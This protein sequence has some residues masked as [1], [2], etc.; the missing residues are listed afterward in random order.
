MEKVSYDGVYPKVT[1]E[2]IIP[3]ITD[4]DRDAVP[5]QLARKLKDYG[6]NGKVSAFYTKDGK[7]CI[8]FFPADF[9]DC[10]VEYCNVEYVVKPEC[11]APTW[12]YV[13]KYFRD[14]LGIY[15]IVDAFYNLSGDIV[16]RGK[17][18]HD[19]HTYYCGMDHEEYDYA[20]YRGFWT[21]MYIIKK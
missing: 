20:L 17:V 7:R 14:M 1:H 4:K 2:D 21:A 8:T 18:L 3:V 11:S 13:R 5:F 12:E 6:F 19:G 15:I 9:N 16:F 10:D